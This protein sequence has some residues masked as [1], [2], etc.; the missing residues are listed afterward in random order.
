MNPTIA[1]PHGS[2]PRAARGRR[3]A[4]DAP[5]A[6][7]ASRPSASTTASSSLTTAIGCTILPSEC[8]H[9]T[10]SSS[11]LSRQHG[12]VID[13]REA[14]VVVGDPEDRH[15]RPPRLLLECLRQAHGGHA[16]VEVVERSAEEGRLLPG[17]DC[18]GVRVPQTVDVPQGRLP[19]AEATVLFEQDVDNGIARQ[20]ARR[21][22]VAGA[23]ERT[24]GRDSRAR[25][26]RLRVRSR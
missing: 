8:R 16:L 23:D 24:R 3:P 2:S 7:P 11:P 14:V 17:H 19:R 10:R 6:D 13:L 1:L 5:A 18:H 15:M 25:T 22:Y 9:A 21:G 12:D 20:L 26:G 4:R